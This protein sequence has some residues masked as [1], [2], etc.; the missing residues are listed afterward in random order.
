MKW[1]R[2]GCSDLSQNLRAAERERENA[3]EWAKLLVSHGNEDKGVVI[4]ARERNHN[5]MYESIIGI[6]KDME[7]L[8]KELEMARD[9]AGTDCAT[10]T[11]VKSK[12]QRPAP[13]F[14]GER[15]SSEGGEYDQRYIVHRSKDAEGRE[16]DDS[17]RLNNSLKKEEGQR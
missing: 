8:G 2:S 3:R 14:V 16:R 1:R 9:K 13:K 6:N 17:R 5:A 10:L 12:S 15:E 11:S 4:K 7:I